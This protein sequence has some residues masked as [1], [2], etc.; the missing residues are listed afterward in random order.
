MNKKKV[1]MQEIADR[2][3]VSKVT[4]SKAL[5]GK[6]GVGAELREKIRGEAR[7]CGYQLSL[8][9]SGKD[10]H[11]KKVVVFCDS[12]FFDETS[13]SYFYVKIYQRIADA[14]LER[15]AIATLVN[16]A[17]QKNYSAQ[18]VLLEEAS[19]DGII[20][21][22]SLDPA[23]VEMVKNTKTP[24][25]F[26]DYYDETRSHDCVLMEN[27][28]NMYD[29]T[30][31]LLECGHR[32][33]GFVG[34]LMV[35]QS[36]NDRF[37]GYQRALLQWKI[38]VREEWLIPERTPDNE[39]IEMQLPEKLP[40]AFV[41]NCDETAYRLMRQLARRGIRV[42]ED[43]SIVSFDDDV[44]ATMTQPPLSTVA[45]HVDDMAQKAADCMMENMKPGY[46]SRGEIH[47]VRGEMVF[48]ESVK[49]R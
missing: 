22:G 24:R 25:I 9:H 36:I 45:V 26:V 20:L 41:C 47:L 14:L 42:P 38:P 3:G 27:F 21:L 15:G 35:T 13:R 7:T 37:L 34:S 19:F 32:E 31:H 49:N 48:R 23:F 1:T 44:F 4:V 28:Y 16:V 40:Q 2:L 18:R 5:N 30:C 29:A 33:I 43:L 39:P 6:E 10:K 8:S 46:R 12:K 17:R 11:V